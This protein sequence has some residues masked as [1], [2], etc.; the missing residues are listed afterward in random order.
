MVLQQ[1]PPYCCTVARLAV[2]HQGFIFFDTVERLFEI[3]YK[4]VFG[5]FYV[6]RLIFRG[7]TQIDNTCVTGV[8]Y[9]LEFFQRD[10]ISLGGL[11]ADLFP[12]L[13]SIEISDSLIKPY[14][15]EL[16]HEI[17]RLRRPR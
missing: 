8:A 4:D 17:L 13:N 7:A 1:R 16:A 12:R 10:D 5:A 15:H 11:A 14:T 6:A 9:C 2:N 3:P